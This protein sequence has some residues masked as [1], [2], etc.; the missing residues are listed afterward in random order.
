LPVPFGDVNPN[1]TSGTSSYNA[2]SVNWR[3]RFSD[4]Y[5]FL[6]SYTWSHAIDDSTDVV[7]TSDAPQSNFN[8]NAERSNSAFDQR[9]RFVLSGVYNSARVGAG[10]FTSA[11]L[12]NVSVAPIIEIASGRPFNILTGTDTNFDFNALTDRPNAV[13]AGSGVTGCGTAPV[14][15]KYSP[16]G[17]FNLPCYI[18][19]PAGSPI[20]AY[21]GNLARNV[22]TKPYVVFT[23]LRI[24]K[25]IGLP[26]E[27]SLQLMMDVFNL[28]NKNNTLDVNL[29]YTAAGQQTAASD[30]RQ[31]QF[32]A[33][34]SF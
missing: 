12:S 20:S 31:F 23:D 7:S 5:E 27:M 9:H 2:L 15:S 25:S 10:G 17:W 34:L 13:A 26:R 21:K 11:V 29:L 3:K 24:A 18:D 14:P 28:I 8:P 22:A 33:R 4:K 32:G 30:P 19:V 16:T 6:A 1:R